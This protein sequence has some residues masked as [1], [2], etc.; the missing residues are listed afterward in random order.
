MNILKENNIT[1]NVDGIPL[2]YYCYDNEVYRNNLVNSSDYNVYDESNNNQWY[3][4][5][6]G[7]TIVILTYLE[8]AA[9]MK[10]AMAYVIL[11]TSYQEAR[12]AYGPIDIM[13]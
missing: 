7:T 5:T 6:I 10:M 11:P 8:K 3:N 1:D 12:T 4:G 13:A 2:N 9:Q